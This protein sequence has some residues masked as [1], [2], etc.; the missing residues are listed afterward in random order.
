MALPSLPVADLV[1][2]QPALSLGRLETLFDLPALS[3]NPHQGS[4]GGLG[5][6]GVA[7]VVGVFE[8]LSETAPHQQRPRPALLLGQTHQGPVI[9][10]FAFAARAGGK[11]FPGAFEG[12]NHFV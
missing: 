7:Q 8:L 6:R 9:E 11:T 4:T 10:A 3:S 5:S 1:V 2:V 12:V